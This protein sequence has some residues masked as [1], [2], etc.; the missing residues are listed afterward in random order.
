MEEDDEVEVQSSQ[1]DDEGVVL[2]EDDEDELLTL[3]S[4]ESMLSMKFLLKN[5][6]HQNNITFY[7]TINEIVKNLNFIRFLVTHLLKYYILINKNNIDYN[8]II[9]VDFIVKFIKEIIDYKAVTLE[10]ITLEETNINRKSNRKSKKNSKYYNN[11]FIVNDDETDNNPHHIVI[12]TFL[13]SIYLEIEDF[14]DRATKI[15]RSGLDYPIKEIAKEIV[16]SY[17]LNIVSNYYNYVINFVN[18]MS[19]KKETIIEINNAENLTAL[20]KKLEIN[21]FI[22]NLSILV[23]DIVNVSLLHEVKSTN[24]LNIEF[25]NTYKK[26][27]FPAKE[28]YAIYYY[29]YYHKLFIYIY[30]LIIF[31]HYFYI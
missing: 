29:I 20:E 25:Y 17:K 3:S 14:M 2:Q 16:K 30:L 10:E 19:F 1:E 7:P 21:K 18:N 6:I 9:S 13:D 8:I 26:I 12:K 11:D 23:K 27:I 15:N 5:I 31:Y 24:V 22:T 28:K 4:K